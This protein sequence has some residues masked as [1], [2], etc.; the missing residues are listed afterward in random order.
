MIPPDIASRLQSSADVALRPVAPTQQ[1]TDKLS[2]L[3][4]GQKVMA[5]IQSMLPNGTYRAL[6][7][8][9]N[10]TLALPFSAKSGDTLELL[11]T[12]SDGKT[13]L[14][15]VS[16]QQANEGK[17]ARD[18]VST[19][20]SQTGK[21]IGQLFSR[22]DESSDDS[23]ALTLN[24]NQPIARTPP[25]SAQELLPLLKQAITQSGMFYESHQAEWV[26]G[27]F[28]QNAL[29]QEPQ[30][31]LSSP[32][33]FAPASPLPLSQ[34][35]NPETSAQGKEAPVATRL[36]TTDPAASPRT[37]N[38]SPPPQASGHLIAPQTQP[39]VQQQLDA[40][41][42][43]HFAWQGQ[44]WPGQEMRWEIEED[45]QRTGADEPESATGW[46]TRLKLTLPTLGSVNA[47]IRLQDQQLVLAIIADSPETRAL[48]QTETGHLYKQ[49]TDAGLSVTSIGISDPQGNG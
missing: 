40:L 26:E 25:S 46:S 49:M 30:G 24:G 42:T 7:N 31:K 21:L 5:E 14:A 10:I 9:R 20:L 23:K 32:N 15:V 27:R 18:A 35:G 38:E 8:Q 6:I 47:Q 19:T 36:P 4:A 3:V 43:Q 45:G 16:H 12:E 22:A 28:S 17:T 41:A 13:S 2:D 34:P 44:V 11:V 33:A 48:M 37:V 1:L 29:L 39:I